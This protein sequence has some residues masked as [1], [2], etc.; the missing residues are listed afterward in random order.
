MIIVTG[1]AGFIG[2]ALIWKLNRLGRRDILV[3]DRLGT[4][5][6]W[7]NLVPLAF[8]DFV[9]KADF[10]ARSADGLPAACEVVFHMGA[11]SS[12]TER[13]ADYLIRNNTRTTVELARTCKRQGIPFIYASSAATYGDGSQGYDDDP[14]TVET[15]EPLNGYGWSKQLADRWIAREGLLAHATGFR[16]FNVFGPNEYHKGDMRSMVLKAWQQVRAGERVKLFAN[17]REGFRDGDESRDFVY[18]KDV[19]DTLVAAWQQPGT[20]GLYNLGTGTARSF[21][22]LVLAVYSALGLP[23]DIDWVPMPESLRGQ[24]QYYT[25]ATT[26]RGRAAGLPPAT[27]SLE[28]A[29]RDYVCNYLEAGQAR[30]GASAAGSPVRVTMT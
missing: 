18:V 8:D 24:Y 22:D 12:T 11:C 27:T 9:D 25:C 13:D 5:D 28:E 16:F 10:Q 4:G 7:R 2:S 3:V 17:H 6:K 19:V 20:P 26:E 23:P 30:L 14:A 21:R 15:L 1:G 29:V